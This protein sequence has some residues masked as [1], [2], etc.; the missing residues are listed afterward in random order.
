MRLFNR[1]F[2][3]LFVIMM[4]LGCSK[5]NAPAA[6]ENVEQA[7]KQSAVTTLCL[8]RKKD[9]R[10]AQTNTDRLYQP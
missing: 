9:I 7:L 8:D 10:L 4:T 5:N 1:I 6:K 3:V 2:V